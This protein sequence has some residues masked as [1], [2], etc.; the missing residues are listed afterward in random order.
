[1]RDELFQGIASADA[2]ICLINIV[3][4]MLYLR[5]KTA[6]KKIET[7]AYAGVNDDVTATC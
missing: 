6:D 1:M 3:I 2:I 5:P 4:K 7:I